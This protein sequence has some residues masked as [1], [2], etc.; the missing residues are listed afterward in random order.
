VTD[1]AGRGDAGASA[2][3]DPKRL[4]HFVVKER[5][6]KGGMGIVYRARDERLRRDVA[7]KV[8]PPGFEADGEK[9]RRFMREARSAAAITHANIAAIHD[10]GEDQGRVFIAMELVEG[11]TLR[12]RMAAGPLSP[13]EVVRIGRGIARGL[14]RAHAKGVVH[15]DLKP[16][17]VMIDLDH[18]PKILDF[19][20]AKIDSSG[21][22]TT[23]IVET[24]S[25]VTEE[26]RLLGTPFYMS[27]EQVLG[28]PVDARSDVF[29]L[30][31]VLYEMCCGK[32]PFG[33]DK[34]GHVL[35]AITQDEPPP[36]REV[37]PGV[38]EALAA[39][40]DKCLRKKKDD[41][42][43]GARELLDALEALPAVSDA[44][45]AASQPSAPSAPGAGEDTLSTRMTAGSHVAHA[46]AKPRRRAMVAL[47][48]I[49]VGGVVAAIAWRSRKQPA[50]T[51]TSAGATAA[52]SAP[53]HGVAIT[54]H[55]PPKTSSPEA[56]AEYSGALH[57]L[58]DGAYSVAN[59]KLSR[60]TALDP[61][62]GAAQ[63]RYIVYMRLLGAEGRTAYA[64]AAQNRSS[65]S[66]RDQALLRAIEPAV[67]PDVPDFAESARRT[68]AVAERWTDDAEIAWI[69]GQALVGVGDRD[70]SLRE[71]D[72]A[73][74]LDEHFALA[75]HEQAAV[76]NLLG[77]YDEALATAGRCL[78]V[79]PI[80]AACARRRADV[81]AMRGQC[82]DLEREA[83][84][85]VAGEPNGANAYRYM[86]LA[87][88]ARR[89]PVE[90]IRDAMQHYQANSSEK[91]RPIAAEQTEAGLALYAGD[92]GAAARH[93]LEAERLLREQ[94]P[95]AREVDAIVLEEESGERSR[96]VDLAQEYLRRDE[97][98]PS[99]LGRG[100]PLWEVHVAG[101]IDAAEFRRRRD[102]WAAQAHAISHRWADQTW[103][104]FYATTSVTAQDAREAL[105][106]LPTYPRPKG[107]DADV[108]DL[109]LFEEP[110][111]RVYLLA[112]QLDDAIVH[113]GAAARSCA[114]IRTL[115]WYLRS[116]EELG[117][118]LAAKGDRA[119]ACEAFHVVL[120]YWGHAKPRS[121][122]ADA[123]RKHAK[124]LG[125]TAEP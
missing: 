8:L 48:V 90:A 92:L 68:R 93:R 49:V 81:F 56:A 37:A 22:A 65:L 2:E 100:V 98:S 121:V 115:V 117:E 11:E 30:G 43:A 40:V 76:H 25:H 35:L 97:P 28:A 91:E 14:A 6:G 85:V 33:G 73:L 67:L 99:P 69:D 42:Y 64:A 88:A 77:E 59:Q 112:G 24:E 63:L 87:L 17:N 46:P 53:A 7:L 39:I 111:G 10:V 45:P 89:A 116:H 80:A 12:A 78:E 60:A 94:D 84:R 103:L 72:R 27:P 47:V 119:G 54:D 52:S 70:A 21:I 13:D 55:P 101:R 108:G 118:A 104:E 75:L 106:A 109:P 86:I 9:R 36:L 57:A 114:G 113:L 96:A 29:S 15:R 107:G 20:L 62:F 41:R 32:R 3:G 31:V 123:A 5:L 51:S 61:N 18:E 34:L 44:R 26:G 83:R 105:E 110:V 1:D 120:S 79:S 71:F 19:G 102:T 124:A 66:D 125:C 38:P 23:E 4:A 16:E 82:S 58:R 95:D 50:S 74:A 122:T